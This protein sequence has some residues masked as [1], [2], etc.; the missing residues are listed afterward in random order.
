MRKPCFKI[1]YSMKTWLVSVMEK[2]TF[3]QLKGNL[4]FEI[5]KITAT[6]KR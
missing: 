2:K 3:S 4:V 1:E 5:L 6:D